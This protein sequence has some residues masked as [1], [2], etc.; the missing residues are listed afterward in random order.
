MNESIKPQ[1]QGIPNTISYP[2]QSGDSHTIEEEKDN[3]PHEVLSEQNQSQIEFK[4]ATLNPSENDIIM[5]EQGSVIQDNQNNKKAKEQTD[6]E[7]EFNDD[8]GSDENRSYTVD[9]I[10]VKQQRQMNRLNTSNS[11]FKKRGQ[12]SAMKKLKDVNIIPYEMNLSDIM[13]KKSKESQRIFNLADD[14]N[15]VHFQNSPLN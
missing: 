5:Q 7:E 8:I 13:S 14:T 2:Q 6:S 11:V 9:M 12:Q 1:C 3:M 4:I 15:D 10:Q